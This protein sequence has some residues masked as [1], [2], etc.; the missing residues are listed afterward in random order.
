[1]RADSTQPSGL[2]I[3]NLGRFSLR[4][5]QTLSVPPLHFCQHHQ[6][7][8]GPDCTC[9]AN[10]VWQIELMA[11]PIQLRYW[12]DCAIHTIDCMINWIYCPGSP[13]RADDGVGS[14]LPCEFSAGRKI[15]WRLRGG[16]RRKTSSFNF[17]ATK[18]RG[19]KKLL[20]AGFVPSPRRG[21]KIQSVPSS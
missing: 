10:W 5:A 17:S 18:S 20:G 6:T 19:G 21:T 4:T 15:H 13:C 16:P 2:C 8:A 3:K 7:H 9:A 12:F 1:V 14:A 11:R